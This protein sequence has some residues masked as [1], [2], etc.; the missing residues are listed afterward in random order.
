MSGVLL[1]YTF[2]TLMS[3]VSYYLPQLHALLFP[4]PS[5]SAC[6]TSAAESRWLICFEALGVIVALFGIYLVWNHHHNGN[7]K[8]K[9]VRRMDV[10]VSGK[11][12]SLCASMNL[13]LSL[14]HRIRSQPPG[15]FRLFS[16][17]EYHSLLLPQC[18]FCERACGCSWQFIHVLAIVFGAGCRIHFGIVLVFNSLHHEI[19]FHL[20]TPIRATC[21]MD[22][23]LCIVGG[24]RLATPLGK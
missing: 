22:A 11:N 3:K 6:T 17:H 7:K 1:T 13:S 21:G 24:K 16:W 23:C 12:V 9:R 5:A 18:L 14:T 2:P 19:P 20:T 4:P 15:S 10:W 8:G